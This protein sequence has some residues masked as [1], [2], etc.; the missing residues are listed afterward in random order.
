M[1]Y[2]KYSGEIPNMESVQKRGRELSAAARRQSRRGNV[3]HKLGTVVFWTV[4]LSLS[5]G[6]IFLI[7]WM[8]PED[9]D[10]VLV[11]LSAVVGIVCVFIAIIIS[12]IM[13]AIAAIP[14]W[15]KRKT[16][17]K[18]ML[19]QALSESCAALRQYY[20]FQEPF[21]VTKCYCSSDKRFDRHDVCIYVVEDELRI[22]ANLHYGFFDPKR[23]L[24]CYCI[25]LE[26]IRLH[27]TRAKDRPAIELTADGVSF[28]LGIKAKSFVEE[29]VVR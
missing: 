2:F 10:V 29:Y 19:R 21:F 4:F 17:E 14:L 12:A 23:D 28:T 24:G 18:A 13:G 8:L 3:L 27:E 9:G 5:A 6:L 25:S 11:I 15:G 26:E 1:H 7:N 16:T 20:Q 22:T